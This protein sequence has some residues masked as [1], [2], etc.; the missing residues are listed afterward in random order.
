ERGLQQVGAAR[1]ADRVAHAGAHVGKGREQPRAA[2]LRYFRARDQATRRVRTVG[3]PVIS[4]A[5]AALRDAAGHSPRVSA[6]LPIYNGAAVLEEAIDSIL[7]QSFRDFELIA[8]D[9]GSRDGSGEILDRMAQADGRVV[10]LHQ[11]N[12]GVIATLNRGLTLA[13]G[14]FIARMDADDVA[15]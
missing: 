11:A 2:Q 15:H 7:R 1:V 13:R 9:D 6:L 14:E 12:A 5:S 8:I 10:A 3:D 4:D